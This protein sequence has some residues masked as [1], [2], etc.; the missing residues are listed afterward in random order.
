MDADRSGNASPFH[1]GEQ[2]VQTRLGVRDRIESFAQRV[3]RDHMPDQ[4]REFYGELPYL[5][6]G[7]VD[8]TGW[9][10]ASMIVGAPGF[11]SADDPKRLRINAQPLV[12]DPL[13][14]TL[15]ADAEIGILG[16]QL[17][18]RRRN[19]M[20]GRVAAISTAGIAVEV[21]QA[22]GNCP[23]YIQARSAELIPAED[24]SAIPEVFHADRLD[25]R[26]REIIST[27]DTLFI[28]TAYAGDE[29]ADR[30]PTSGADVSHRGG[31]PG[32][33]RVDDDGSFVFPDFSGN[34]HFNTVGNLV[35][36]PKAGLLFI[37]FATGEMLYLTGTTEIQWD[38]EE[39][40]A[41]AGAERLIRVRPQQVVRVERGLPL[42]FDLDNYSPTLASTGNW[43][44]AA[45]IIAVNR[46][47]NSYAQYGIIDIKHESD[48][49][50][51]FYLRRTDG[52]ALP[53]FRPGQFLP[54]RL[55]IPGHSEPALRTYTLSDAPG[56]N[57]FRL[58]IKR[59]G[60][61]AVVS[62]HFH[63]QLNLGDRVE[64]MAPRGK[65]LLDEVSDRPVVLISGGVGITPMVAIANHIENEGHRTRHYL[66]KTHI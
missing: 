63:D 8:R 62:T 5:L 27:A 65:F 45:E 14:Q 32:F 51:S 21:D 25:P 29:A 33:V 35:Q 44:Q 13:N 34:N 52:K 12:G 39:V 50:S 49:I 2:E 64:A 66:Y 10:W 61:D 30:D 26:A 31:S 17:Q 40:D 3:V 47:R 24:R 15:R 56:E 41:F 6:V 19:R 59:E 16:I 54:I 36:N 46:D 9:P 55:D 22:F 42:K 7:T 1:Q 37:D 4:H 23:Q 18:T 11:L 57:A 58:S 28:A 53:S 43:Q 48:V 38:G 20:N 60:G